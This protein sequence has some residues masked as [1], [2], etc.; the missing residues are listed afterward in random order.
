MISPSANTKKN[1][2]TRGQ[3]VKGETWIQQHEPHTCSFTAK[4]AQHNRRKAGT[5]TRWN[6][7]MWLSHPQD[8]DPQATSRTP[9]DTKKP[10]NSE[11]QLSQS[12][13][14]RPRKKTLSSSINT[15]YNWEDQ[16]IIGVITAPMETKRI[17]CT[18]RNRTRHNSRSREEEQEAERANRIA[19]SREYAPKEFLLLLLLQPT[20]SSQWCGCD[21]LS[22]RKM[23]ADLTVCSSWGAAQDGSDCCHRSRADA[24]PWEE[25]GRWG[26]VSRREK[27]R[28]ERN[29]TPFPPCQYGDKIRSQ[30]NNTKRKI[31]G[32]KALPLSSL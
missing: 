18:H 31:E 14:E 12:P 9:R 2:K 19:L 11:R 23:E 10:H 32:R 7:P 25:E 27:K 21:W 30:D 4:R 22:N 1:K 13:Q 16:P 15:I 6:F 3:E 17:G 24:Q 28:G 5:Q 8:T 29:P 26:E 20:G